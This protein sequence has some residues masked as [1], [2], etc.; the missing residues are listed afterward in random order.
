MSLTEPLNPDPNIFAAV[1]PNLPPS[2]SKKL[3]SKIVSLM[4]GGPVLFQY[5]M[6]KSKV[7][8][9]SYFEIYITVICAVQL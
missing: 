9:H 5:L 8:D 4:T 1:I 3:N 7:T 2:N 6:S